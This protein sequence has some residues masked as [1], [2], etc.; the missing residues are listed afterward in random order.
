MDKLQDILAGRAPREPEAVR[1]V[2][3]YVMEEFGAAVSVG[4][5]DAALV[6]HTP[7]AALAGALRARTVQLRKLCGEDKRLV[8]RID[9]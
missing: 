8:F 6:I 2:K 4:V 7:S 9:G 5:T 3:K 1:L